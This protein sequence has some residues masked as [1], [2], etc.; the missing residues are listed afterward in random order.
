MI[1]S[2]GR[3]PSHLRT[4]LASALDSGHISAMPSN[5]AIRSALGVSDYTSEVSEGLAG[6]A[7]LGITG[8][9]AGAWLN[10][11]EL[12]KASTPK[13]DLVWSGPPVPGLFAR[14]TRQVYEELI[15]SAQHSLWVSTFAFYDGAKAFSVL[16]G[17]ME[18]RPQ[19]DV[20]LL[21]NIQR[22]RYDTSSGDQIVRRFAEHFWH[23]EWPGVLRP[24]V[25]YDPRSVELESSNAVLHAKAVVAD[26]KSTFVT[27]ANLTEAAL[28]SNVELGVLV[29]DRAFALT[30]CGYFQG[31]INIGLLSSLPSS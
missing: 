19:L 10:A 1:S 5:E 18:Q 25:F 31:L 17:A 22:R 29:V 3:I 24:A 16:S 2:L 28:D 15:S 8:R 26:Q 21:V 7:A 11:L 6:L 9:A 27:S 14:D 30:V 23:H 12:A 13:P 20:K 4:R